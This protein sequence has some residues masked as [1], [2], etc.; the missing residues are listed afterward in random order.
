MGVRHLGTPDETLWGAHHRRERFP[1]S[2]EGQ[3]LTLQD[4]P[5]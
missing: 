1:E 2:L 5:E 4:Q 3:T